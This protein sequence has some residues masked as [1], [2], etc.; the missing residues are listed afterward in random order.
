MP[1][2]TSACWHHAQGTPGAYAV[3]DISEISDPQAFKKVI[4]TMP[5][6]ADPKMIRSRA[7]TGTADAPCFQRVISLF[8]LC[9]LLLKK[10][11]KSLIT[12]SNCPFVLNRL[13]VFLGKSPCFREK[14]DSAAMGLAKGEA[15]NVIFIE[16]PTD[17]ATPELGAASVDGR[18]HQLGMSCWAAYMPDDMRVNAAASLGRSNSTPA[19]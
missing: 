16:L 5:M 13:P 3:V 19:F 1:I 11:S 4:D 6:P 15:A 10:L 8:S 9:Y 7:R 18:R 12:L 14:T 2:G 17:P